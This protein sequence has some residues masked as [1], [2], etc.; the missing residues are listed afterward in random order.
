M[1]PDL[2]GVRESSVEL[3]KNNFQSMFQQNSQTLIGLSEALA[4]FFL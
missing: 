4:Y 2:I 1:V 3:D